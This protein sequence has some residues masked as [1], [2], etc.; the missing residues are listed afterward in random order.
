[1]HSVC[2]KKTTIINVFSLN[3]L[4]F[5]NFFRTFFSFSTLYEN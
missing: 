4:N 2:Q 3:K 1:M 5:Q